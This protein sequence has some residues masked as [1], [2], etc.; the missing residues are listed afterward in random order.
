MAELIPG[1]NPLR[2]VWFYQR[3]CRGYRNSL[4]K[5]NMHVW[6]QAAKKFFDLISS[7]NVILPE[8]Y[9][10]EQTRCMLIIVGVF[11]ASLNWIALPEFQMFVL[12]FG[13]TWDSTC[14]CWITY[15]KII[16]PVC[17]SS[18]TAHITWLS[19]VHWKEHV[20]NKGIDFMK[21]SHLCWLKSVPH[22]VSTVWWTAYFIYF[23]TVLR[24]IFSRNPWID[25]FYHWFHFTLKLDYQKLGF[26]NN[27]GSIR[28]SKS[29]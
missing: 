17:G 3:I 15:I 28:L 12:C 29:L 1:P 9:T 10:R 13:P 20:A 14:Q 7:R 19:D 27:G 25:W 2:V 26:P 16:W 6:N 23:H 21:S 5:V 4:C 18:L 22:C 24:V 11:P 8:V